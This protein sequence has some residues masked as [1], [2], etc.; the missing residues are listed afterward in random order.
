[1]VEERWRDASAEWASKITGAL[2]VQAWSR[3]RHIGT[4]QARF[5]AYEQLLAEL[6]QSEAYR[7]LAARREGGP[8]GD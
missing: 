4:A 8:Q 3:T 5:H 7:R 2:W 6:E 1:M